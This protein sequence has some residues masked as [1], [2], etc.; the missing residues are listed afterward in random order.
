MISVHFKPLSLLYVFTSFYLFQSPKVPDGRCNNNSECVEGETVIAG[1]GKH[2]T[3]MKYQAFCSL[4]T[5]LLN[6]HKRKTFVK[7]QDSCSE[8]KD[9]T[10]FYTMTH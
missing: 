2:K 10:L 8:K 5:V 4:M 7:V 1:H 6:L 9:V 3:C